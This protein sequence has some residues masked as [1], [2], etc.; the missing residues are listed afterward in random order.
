MLWHADRQGRN[1]HALAASIGRPASSLTREPWF[2]CSV[3]RVPDRS[4]Q[5]RAVPETLFALCRDLDGR[6]SLRPKTRRWGA[7]ETAG[8][9]QSATA[10]TSRQGARASLGR[11]E[12]FAGRAIERPRAQRMSGRWGRPDCVEPLS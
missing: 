12:E 11:V 6:S 9:L 3:H 7:M 4:A 10:P 1:Q 8:R 5:R 2:W